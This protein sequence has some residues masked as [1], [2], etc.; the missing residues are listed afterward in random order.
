MSKEKP[1]AP[2]TAYDGLPL[3]I[4]VTY[5]KDISFENL[6]P[7]KTFSMQE[8]P[9]ISINVEVQG[10]G[11]AEQTYEVELIVRAEATH[12]SEKMFIF[13]LTYAGIFTIT[14][15]D[16]RALKEMLLID[17]PR[18][19]FPF[20]RAIIAST[21]HEASVVPINLAM[22]DFRKLAESQGKGSDEMQG[23]E[24]TTSVLN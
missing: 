12:K 15:T 3:N 10:R 11:V 14:E 8:N 17:C 4:N 9:D 6:N 1:T 5:V 7:L 16:E 20:A 18:I 21:T 23:S 13:E 19:L 2:V 24:G 22:I